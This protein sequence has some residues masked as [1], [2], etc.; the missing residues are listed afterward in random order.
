MLVLGFVKRR[1]RDFR[2]KRQQAHLLARGTAPEIT[3][4][5]WYRSLA[6]P[7]AFYEDVFCYFHFR[8]PSDIRDH[9]TYFAAES[10]GFGEAA[11]HVMWLV[12]FEAFRF[13]DF[14][15]IGV[16]R[17]Q[18]L[19]LAALLQRRLDIQGRI[20]GIS[21]FSSE[22]DSTCGYMKDLDYYRDTLDNF[23]HFDLPA[24]EL[25]VGRSTDAQAVN[26]IRE[27]RWDCVYIDGNHDYDFVRAD[28]YNCA[29]Y[30]K[31]GGI[32]VLDDAGLTTNFKPPAFATKGIPG[33][34]RLAAEIGPPFREILQVGHNRVFQRSDI[35][36]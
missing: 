13:R 25:V 14:V 6:Q 31:P 27:K 23:N 1:V 15:E 36:Y 32:I 33:P 17:G 22:G 9:R 24:P 8:L 7:T 16:Y 18:T 11:F 20:V 26:V 2:S 21:P 30:I 3:R 35:S 12:L 28:W 19:S 34:S 10:R 4:A 29:P 5:D